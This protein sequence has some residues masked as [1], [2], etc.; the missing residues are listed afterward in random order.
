MIPVFDLLVSK[1]ESTWNN[2]QETKKAAW[3]KDMSHL[4]LMCQAIGQLA[5]GQT[6]LSA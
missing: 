4:A 6:G 5:A 3:K 1:S 2:K